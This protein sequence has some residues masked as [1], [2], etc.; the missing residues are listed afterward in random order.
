MAR[1]LVVED[2]DPI[3]WTLTAL[4]KSKGHRVEQAANGQQALTCCA[5]QSFDLVLMDVYMPCM[6]GFE[7]CRRLRQE[8][9]VPILM[10]S[11]NPDP[12]IHEHALAC[13]ANGFITKPLNIDRLLSWI[14]TVT[15]RGCGMP[16]LGLLAV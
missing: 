2:N 12:F 4:L 3:R 1:I 10:I 6:N 11:T 15:P 5:R 8:S 14:G 9:H 16:Y 7:A 13:G